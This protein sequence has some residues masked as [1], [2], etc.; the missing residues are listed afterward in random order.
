MQPLYANT[1]PNI[2]YLIRNNKR[3][4]VFAWS[5]VTSRS[6]IERWT[7]HSTF[8]RSIHSKS[9]AKLNKIQLQHQRG[10][11]HL[12][13]F[14]VVCVSPKLKTLNY[15]FKETNIIRIIRIQRRKTQVVRIMQ[16]P[17]HTPNQ[18]RLFKCELP[19]P[20][21]TLFV[22]YSCIL[23][24]CPIVFSVKNFVYYAERVW[25]GLYIFRVFGY[26][27][28]FYVP[29]H[30]CILLAKYKL[31]SGSSECYHIMCRQ[32]HFVTECVRL[33]CSAYLQCR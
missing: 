23:C 32:V 11:V 30:I 8:I 18:Q 12:N 31:L 6:Y 19:A 15:Y 20:H 7:L 29:T 14:F 1:K 26:F 2:V 22:F 25:N 21:Y 33:I 28:F 13:I 10:L 16:T 24:V 17:L 4:C 27:C 9:Y 3:F 5:M